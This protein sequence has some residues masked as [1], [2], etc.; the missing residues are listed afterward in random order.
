MPTCLL[1]DS[2]VI[3]FL[4]LGS[5][6]IANGFLTAEQFA[7]EYRFELGASFCPTC[8]MVQ[9]NNLVE[10]EKLF[11]DRYA[12]YSSTSTRMGE[13]FK[14][15]A[16]GL[17]ATHAAGTDPFVVE[18]GSNDGIML[19]HMAARG[20][21]HLGIEPSENVARAARE[22]GVQTRCA[23]FDRELAAEITAEYGRA[24]VVFGANVMCHIPDLH[25][26]VSGIGRLLKPTGVLVFED[27]YWGDIIEKT[28]FDQ[29]YDEHAFYFSIGAV[30]RLFEPHGMEVVDVE[31]LPVHGGSM[32]YTIA[33][34]GSHSAT[35]AVDARR[36]KERAL[37]LD[38]EE[39]Y[40][41]FARNVERSR[42]ELVGLL[43][44]LREEGKRVVGYAATSK[45]TT[46]TNYCG[47]TPELVEFI[48]DTTPIKQGRYS[49]GTHIP[50]RPHEE[51][52]SNYPDYAILF[53]WNHAGEIMAKEQAFT[54]GGGKW[55][56]YVPRVHVL[57]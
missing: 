14:R 33:R 9:L 57:G 34:S 26:V 5:M 24:D 38:R 20:V 47:I 32:R 56:L 21:R 42:D 35:P 22:K 13:H 16:K 27:P 4:S 43:R 6:P 48:S 19:K 37:G 25:S 3:P 46:V 44:R 17:L 55:I 1:C 41:R 29:I 2:A 39:T 50:I 28:S 18:I 10:R 45:S 30:E 40:R 7:D 15:L 31:P 53:G 12:F 23:F 52:S 8:R 49:P 54:A 36:A 11:H 51:F